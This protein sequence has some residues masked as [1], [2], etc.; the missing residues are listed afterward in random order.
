MP[1]IATSIMLA[2]VFLSGIFM[3][4][5]SDK[6]VD[7]ITRYWEKITGADAKDEK[8]YPSSV[9][10]S[11]QAHLRTIEIRIYRIFGIFFA[12]TALTVLTIALLEIF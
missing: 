5:F 9:V 7:W 2:F 3:A 4:I 1:I 6:L 8:P 10:K 12:V 11:A